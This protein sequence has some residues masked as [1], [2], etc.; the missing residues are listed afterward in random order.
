MDV[1]LC[2]A[3]P[4]SS[5]WIRQ[6]RHGRE[7]QAGPPGTRGNWRYSTRPYIRYERLSHSRSRVHPKVSIPRLARVSAP[8]SSFSRKRR[9]QFRCS[10]RAP[11]ARHF[12]PSP[13]SITCSFSILQIFHHVGTQDHIYDTL[14]PS[15][16]ISIG[17]LRCGVGP[18]AAFPWPQD[19]S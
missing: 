2:F 11:R 18:Q 12:S 7:A 14:I 10:P 3:L 5:R 17:T 8:V 6:Q 16:I 1:L 13:I 9:T 19:L 15:R 4:T